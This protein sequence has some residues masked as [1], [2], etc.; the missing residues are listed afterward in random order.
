MVIDVYFKPL[1]LLNHF[2]ATF[3]YFRGN[4]SDFYNFM[5]SL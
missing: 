5:L 3:N 2:D 1:L 4:F